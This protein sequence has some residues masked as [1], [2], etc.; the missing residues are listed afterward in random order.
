MAKT[1]WVGK[2]KAFRQLKRVAPAVENDLP[3]ALEQNANEVADLARQYAPKRTGEYAQSIKAKETETENGLPAWGI[4]AKY[5]WRFLEFGTS[6]GRYRVRVGS[7]KSDVKQHKTRGRFSYRTHPGN[8]AQPHIWPAYRVIKR[9]MMS[10][11]TRTINKAIK[12]AA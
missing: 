5:I 2:E 8:R 10:R 9:R 6:A 1:R 3:K 12:R 4:F 7:R 11:I